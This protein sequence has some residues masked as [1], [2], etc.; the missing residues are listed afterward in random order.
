MLSSM[1]RY[2]YLP[3]KFS[4][5]IVTILFVTVQS[6][7]LLTKTSSI[8]KIAVTVQPLISSFSPLAII[9]TSRYLVFLSLILTIPAI[10]CSLRLL[11][12]IVAGNMFKFHY[13]LNLLLIFKNLTFEINFSY[14][15]FC[16]FSLMLSYTVFVI[17][18]SISEPSLLIIATLS[19]RLQFSAPQVQIQE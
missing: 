7:A 5:G 1:L 19:H 8:T 2:P 18:L 6:T 16:V 12:S 11:M 13:L 17:L 10:R 15:D 3:L 14:A 4:S 9:V